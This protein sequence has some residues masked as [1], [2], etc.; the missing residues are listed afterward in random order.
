MLLQRSPSAGEGGKCHSPPSGRSQGWI[1][2]GVF[3]VK[4][5]FFEIVKLLSL[6]YGQ[7]VWSDFGEVYSFSLHKECVLAPREQNIQESCWGRRAERRSWKKSWRES[8]SKASQQSNEEDLFSFWTKGGDWV[9]SP[10]P[11]GNKRSLQRIIFPEAS[12]KQATRWILFHPTKGHHRD[13][14]KCSTLMSERT[15]L[16]IFP[17]YPEA[18]SEQEGEG[19]KS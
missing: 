18:Y 6:G 15:I 8:R 7:L 17:H 1:I 19:G 5:F 13:W 9:I 4:S 12:M 3:V 2:M 11:D 10:Q 14:N 16:S